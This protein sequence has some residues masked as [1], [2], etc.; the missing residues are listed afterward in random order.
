MILTSSM[1][2]TATVKETMVYWP[3]FLGD[4]LDA[5]ILTK[6]SMI[7]K[8]MISIQFD[9]GI[10]LNDLRCRFLRGLGHR[11]GRSRYR[12]RRA[13]LARRSGSKAKGAPV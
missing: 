8:A 6:H 1:P 13:V 12:V 2:E 5:I 9:D 4:D 3:N 10:T 7:V 11:D